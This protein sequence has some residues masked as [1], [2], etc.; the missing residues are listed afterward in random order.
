[1]IAEKAI[2]THEKVR[3]FQNRLYLTAKADRKRRFYALYDKIYRNDILEE[4][5]KRVKQNGGTGGIDKVSIDDVKTYGEEKLLGEIAEELRTGKYRCKPV[6]RSY[7]P[8]PDGRKRA[9]GI[10]TIKDRIVQM[11]AKI[12]IEPVFEADFQPCSYGFRPKRSAKQA[13]DRIF[14]VSDKGGALW[15]IDADIKDYFGSINHDKLLL[16]VKQRITDRRVLKLIKG[17][18]KAGVL[19]NGRYSESTL[20]AP[21]G[22]V[23]SP[24]LSNIYLNY[25]D[26]YWNKAF[27][28]LGELV[29]YADD[30][31]IL[32]KRLSHAEEAF[33]AVKWIMG[34]LELTL[35]SEKT[36]LVD[37]YFGKDSFDF[38]GFNNR[39][40]RFRN[41]NWQWYWTLQ[42]IP[43]KKA[44]KKMRANI[45]EVFASPSKLLLS[46]EEMVKLLN[47]TIIGMRNY[48]TRR[49]TRPWLWKIDK[50]INFK[51]TRW[52]NRKKQRN[53]RLGNAAKVRELT[54]QAGLASMCG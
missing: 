5:W 4:A 6:R 41:K 46:M 19:E 42:Q 9:L 36:R 18:L 53:Y 38:L 1:M 40:Q 32:C 47:P 24:L 20:G 26:V 45:K 43:S 15:V 27:G 17:W 44:M 21:Q 30:F 31:V 34:K 48:Y 51:F 39:F 10:P 50:Y 14:E 12:V 49:F 8:K 23:I 35:H 11:A 2:N 16:L 25:F 3:D 29:R 52:Y 37:M 33:R 22:G 54:K 13:M 7:I 28:H